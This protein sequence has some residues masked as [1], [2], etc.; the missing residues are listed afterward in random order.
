MKFKRQS[1]IALQNHTSHVLEALTWKQSRPEVFDQQL[2]REIENKTEKNISGELRK[3]TPL[4][5]LHFYV[6]I[7][8]YSEHDY[9]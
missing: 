5:H 6:L 2:M 7:S 1:E 4:L 3:N 8:S 9:L